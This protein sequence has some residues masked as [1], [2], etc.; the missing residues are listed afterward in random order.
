MSEQLRAVARYT[1]DI[2]TIRNLL[3]PQA[4][5]ARK[6]R[7][8]FEKLAARFIGDSDPIYEHMGRTMQ[9][10]VSGLFAGGDDAELPQDNLDLERFFRLPKS[11]ERRIH[12]RAHA[13]VRIVQQGA[14]LILVLDAHARHPEPFASE[15]LVPF[16]DATLPPEQ[17][18]SEQRR[19]IMRLARSTK[20]R[21]ALLATLESRYLTHTP[22][23]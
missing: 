8:A 10:F 3:S 9:S 15:E 4:G 23:T 17:L 12:G 5:T 16:A 1:A 19:R 18:E 7:C 11:H 2:S 6:R 13:G 14:S 22:A 21:P 20:R